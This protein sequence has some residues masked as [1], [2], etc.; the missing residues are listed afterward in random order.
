MRT[1]IDSVAYLGYQPQVGGYTFTLQQVR[2]SSA[3][4]NI[5]RN[6]GGESAPAVSARILAW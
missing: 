1:A 6:C 4:V 5:L 2:F 3:Y